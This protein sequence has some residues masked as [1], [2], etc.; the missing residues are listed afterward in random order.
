MIEWT[1]EESR[2]NK[3]IKIEA[4][5]IPFESEHDERASINSIQLNQ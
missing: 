1:G 3:R 5:Q 2:D 4:K